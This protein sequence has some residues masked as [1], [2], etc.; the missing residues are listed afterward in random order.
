[1]F[2]I[3]NIHHSVYELADFLEFQALK[4]GSCAINDLRSVLSASDDELDLAGIDE[5]DDKVLNKLQEALQHCSYRGIDFGGYPYTINQNSITLTSAL[6]D[7]SLICVFL[8]LANRLDMQKERMQGGKNATELFERLCRVIVKNYLGE[9]SES[10][11]FGTAASGNF[12]KKVKYILEKLNI[13]GTFKQPYGGTERQKD[14]GVDIVAWIP[15]KDEKDSQLIA[16]GQCK[17]GTNWEHLM[18]KVAFFDLFSTQQ[19]FVAPIHMFF[20]AEDFGKY[21]WQERSSKGGI[22]F[23][24]RRILDLFPQNVNMLDSSLISDIVDWTSASVEY[25]K[26]YGL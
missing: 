15:F 16:L 22:I 2:R 6:E 23:D 10:E 11:I 21:K 26:A 19:S 3:D 12:E 24:R 13:H 8:L 4:R 20:V 7:K 17:T 1:M 25:V 18:R 14:G 5:G 9:H